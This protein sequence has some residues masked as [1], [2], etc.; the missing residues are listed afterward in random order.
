MG[1]SV[2]IA[3]IEIVHGLSVPSF[4]DSQASSTSSNVNDP[5][6]IRPAESHEAWFDFRGRFEELKGQCGEDQR[7][8]LLW[9]ARHGE[10]YHNVGI[11]K[12]G[13][14][15]WNGPLARVN[16]DGEIV[17]GP[18]PLLT[19]VGESQAKALNEA[20]K[21][22]VASGMHTPERWYCSPMRRTASTLELTFDSLLP[23]HIRPKFI[24][25]LREHHGVHTCDKRISRTE[26]GSLFPNFE[27]PD[28]FSEEDILW[29][30]DH[31]ETE[32]ELRTRLSKA[33]EEVILDG[34]DSTFISITSHSGAI[35][36]M[37]KVIGHPPVQ[38][39]T[40]GVVPVILK[41]SK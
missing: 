6:L 40:G 21:A 1:S 27:F 29:D 34:W 3:K 10:G 19:P 31:R 22:A 38:L 32:E 20:W 28:P 16:G 26:L 2:L 15:T 11:N 37:L 33:I 36:A 35:R 12:Y 7:V 23:P 25:N 30:P 9:I 17:W 13:P 39:Q 4:F 18:D 8:K 5:L 14:E 41:I 24:E